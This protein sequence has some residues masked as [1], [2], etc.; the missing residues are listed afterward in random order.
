MTDVGNNESAVSTLRQHMKAEGRTYLW[1]SRATGIP[2]KRLLSE[3]KH[4]RSRLS[5][6][7]AL[8]VSEALDIELPELIGR[9]A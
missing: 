3:I 2:Y 7:T 5:L 4:E 1:L 6:E 9:A 8:A